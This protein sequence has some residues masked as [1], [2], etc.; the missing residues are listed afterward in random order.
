MV[1]RSIEQ[2]IRN[3]NFGTRNGNQEK[4]AVVKNQGTKQRALR[5]LGDCWQWESNGQCS[6]GD[7]S[8]FRHD[9]DKRGKVTQPN[10]SPNYFMQQ[11][12]RNAS[13]TRSPRGRS[14]SRRVFRLPR[15]DY[16]KRTCTNSFCE[17][18][19]SRM[20]VFNKTKGGCRLGQKCSYAHRQVDEQLKKVQKWWQK[21]SGPC[22]R[23]MS[24]TIQRG[25]LLYTTHQMHDNWVAYSRIRSRR[26]L[27]RFYGR[28]QT[29][30]NRSDV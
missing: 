27:H 28:A 25:N 22:W 3:K 4:N 15:K 5:I 1:K 26:S 24:R 8:S 21:C 14:P 13:K 17:V 29:C 16:L 20:L 2:D 19:P 6:R 9:I 10:P 30:G 11:N 18:A 12:E 7:N 23:S